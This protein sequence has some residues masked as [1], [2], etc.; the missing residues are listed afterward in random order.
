M[1]R[2]TLYISFLLVVPLACLHASE[3]EDNVKVVDSLYKASK[4]DSALVLSELALSQAEQELGPNN[5][6]LCGILLRRAIIQLDLRHFDESVSLSKRGLEI[7]ESHGPHNS[8][9]LEFQYN[10][11]RIY[12]TRVETDN[13]RKTIQESLELCKQLYGDQDD[14]H[15][16][17]VY[18][19][20]AM[21]SER[22]G[23]F[24]KADSLLTVALRIFEVSP[25]ENYQNVL[26][27]LTRLAS[28]YED[29]AMYDKAE[30]YYKK[31]I[32]AVINRN[33]QEN[34]FYV[35]VLHKYADLTYKQGRFGTA[36]SLYRD[37]IRLQEQYHPEGRLYLAKILISAAS[38]YIYR[39][40]VQQAEEYLMRSK[41]IYEQAFGRNQFYADVINR[42]GKLYIIQKRY[43]EADSLLKESLAIRRRVYGPDHE[44]V[45]HSLNNLGDLYF[46]Q[47]QYPQAKDYYTQALEIREKLFGQF[48]PYVFLI[49]QSLAKLYATTG[50]FSKSLDYYDRSIYSLRK[51]LDY[52]FTSASESQKLK[53]IRMYPPLNNSLLSL[54]VREKDRRSIDVAYN[55]VLWGKSL[56]VDAL[57]KEN[58]IAACS[59][60]GEIDSLLQRRNDLRTLIANIALGKANTPQRINA[61]KE[62]PALM[63]EQD[64][65]EASLSSR[66]ADFGDYLLNAGANDSI[67]KA[68][69]PP[70]AILCEFVKYRPYDF[71]NKCDSETDHYLVFAL[72]RTDTTRIYDCGSAATIDS[73]VAMGR[74]ILYS[75]NRS[76][77]LGD[78]DESEDRLRQIDA[79]LYDLLLGPLSDDLHHV[80]KII[81]SPDG[82]L[83]LLQFA[84]LVDHKNRYLVECDPIQYLSS[85]LDLIPQS[86]PTNRSSSA[87]LFA[88]P[89][90]DTR[91]SEGDAGAPGFASFQLISNKVRS[92]GVLD[93]L[94]SEFSPLRYSRNES[95][96]IARILAEDEGET[97]REFYGRAASEENIK[98]IL[99]PPD[100]LHIA[101]HGFY[102]TAQDTSITNGNPLFNSCLALAGANRV[103]RGTGV[104]SNDKEDGI[105]TAYEV[106][107]LNLTGTELVSLSACESGV[108]GLLDEEGVQGEGVFGL[109][110]AFRHAGAR[111]VLMSLWKVPDK[112]SAG[113]MEMF[114][115]KWQSGATMTA[116]MRQTMLA[117]MRSSQRERHTSHPIFWGGF[118]LVGNE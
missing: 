36:D 10:L 15:Y 83:N 65:V 4:L 103:V 56:V 30:F 73:L 19:M 88:D 67:V 93:C 76:Y 35:L 8:R 82:M 68:N 101:T 84:M 1:K 6:K 38:L 18:G 66:C 28:L 111:S 95:K 41:A 39:E 86:H 12:Y 89:D 42:L 109:R 81:I 60:D 100:V 117:M 107:G 106:S 58:S 57:M 108:G 7:I 90:F 118:V 97:V 54:G 115:T 44:Y 21:Q 48:H 13:L 5:M 113:F 47:G 105:L 96:T 25:D 104:G 51:F 87:C 77:Y 71:T 2:F 85:A 63:E 29:Q 102:C 45:S 27:T 43:A 110:R 74:E 20:S 59:D 94:N 37:I 22:D 78:I 53:W 75:A 34:A 23:D 40:Q 11:L 9:S 26:L 112:E 16:A 33:D 3:W 91:S 99:G 24:S 61:R 50:E 98:G 49:L 14:V 80:S 64:S 52:S 55:M 116:A 32:Q 92:L 46:Q 70:E 114:Y 72:T 69:I 17:E 62:L 31:A 79:R